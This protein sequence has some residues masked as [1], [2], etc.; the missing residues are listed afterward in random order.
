MTRFASGIIAGGI[1]GAVGM[2]WLMSD[3]KTRRRMVRG[4][5]RAMRKAD[6]IISGV[7]DIF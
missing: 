2:S 3:N 4:H 7:S 6:D 5:R 1:I